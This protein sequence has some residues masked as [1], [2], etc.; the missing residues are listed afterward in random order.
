M[1]KSLILVLMAVGAVTLAGCQSGTKK[2][3]TVPVDRVYSGVLPCADCSGI[4]ATL[5][6]QQDGSYVEQLVYLDTKDGSRSFHDSGKWNIEGNKLR[7][8]N[9]KG[10]STYFSQSADEQS[11]TLLDLEG[12]LIETQL[13]YT[14]ERVKPSKK[15]GQYRYMADAA[16][17]TECESGRQYTASG[18]ELEKAYSKTGVDG[19][20]PVYVEVEGYYTVRP[21]MEDGQF[22]SALVQTG[23]I[24]FDKTAS[25]K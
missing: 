13:N 18:L 22:D 9:P 17:F 3:Q 2:A 6:L 1:K 24:N 4:E 10:E 21:S 15:A 20:T 25:C 12:N 14:L 16:V 8:T 23:K 7:M 19:G 5:L 11:V